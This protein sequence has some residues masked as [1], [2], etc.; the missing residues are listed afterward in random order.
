MEPR[1]LSCVCATAN[2]CLRAEC[3]PPLLISPLRRRQSRRVR[4]RKKGEN[5]DARETQQWIPSPPTLLGTAA[6]HFCHVLVQSHMQMHKSFILDSVLTK[7]PTQTIL[8]SWKY[9]GIENRKEFLMPFYLHT[10]RHHLIICSKAER[11]PSAQSLMSLYWMTLCL[12]VCCMFTLGCR[13]R[14]VSLS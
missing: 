12:F 8:L 3:K 9:Q 4:G 5:N 1:T 7:E 13:V 2:V 14:M 10:Q 11:A 6:V